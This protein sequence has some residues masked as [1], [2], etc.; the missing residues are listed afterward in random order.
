MNAT[1][2]VHG[3]L[4]ILLIRVSQLFT[5]T[6]HIIYVFCS[7]NL[8]LSQLSPFPYLCQ[9]I[10]YQYELSIALFLV[11]PRACAYSSNQIYLKA[12]QANDFYNMAQDTATSAASA[13]SATNDL[14]GDP[15]VAPVDV[16]VDTSTEVV[17]PE[18]AD[19]ED[20]ATSGKTPA[21][22]LLSIMRN[23]KMAH[24][25]HVVGSKTNGHTEHH[26][27][28][29]T[30]NTD[31]SIN[32]VEMKDGEE[33]GEGAVV[34]SS[35]SVA[36]VNGTPASTKKTSN[37]SMKK[38][39]SAIPEHKSKKLNKKKSKP[40]LRLEAK[41][42][43]LFLAR[44]KGHPPWPSII[45]DEEMLPQILLSSRPITTAQPDGTFKKPEYAD[46][47]KRAFERTY[48]IMFL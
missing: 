32:D 12:L 34:P 10:S 20:L 7:R 16:K 6:S 36:A 17:K 43:D 8:S 35:S 26:D 3:F 33:N 31:Q 47:G 48:P 23:W 28:A 25:I 13:A 37:G 22:I 41:P 19:D 18:V 11:L 27:L 39:S 42:G 1:D 2:C 24:A 38:K 5:H 4:R 29:T 15:G 45:C 21:A 46:G 30:T 44:M 14:V 40:A 9:A